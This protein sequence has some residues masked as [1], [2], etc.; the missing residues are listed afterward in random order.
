MN[1]D[2]KPYIFRGA[3]AGILLVLILLLAACG[4]NEPPVLVIPTPVNGT[5]AVPTIAPTAAVEL[6]TAAPSALVPTATPVAPQPSATLPPPPTVAPPLPTGTTG[7]QPTVAP[8]TVQPTVQPTAS[9]LAPNDP[10]AGSGYRVAF[11]AADD[12]LNVRRRPDPDSAVVAQLLPGTTGIRVIDEGR[13]VRGGSLWLPVE[14][15]SGDGWVNSRF[16]TE[17]V[18][19]DV[20]CAD[21]AVTEL[22][23]QLEKAIAE[24]DGRL[25]RSL[26]HPERGLRVRL[27][28]WNPEVEFAG[29]DVQTIF[30]ARIRYDWGTEDGSGNPIRGSFSDVAL[31]RLERDLLAATEWQCD[32]GVF[33]PT[34]GMTILPEGYEP[35]RFYSAHRAAPA[36]QELNWGTWLVGVERWEGRYYVSYLVHYRWE[37]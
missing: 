18:S 4:G 36:E 31:P 29:E 16:L 1:D 28:W 25:I 24:R 27:N 34:A 35:V 32:A 19:H 23:G 6:P 9:P 13:S 22:L 8:P 12:V 17:D 15:A 20:F 3:W 26:I 37:I 14:T 21:P 7:P 30:R 5:A 11:V 33:G 10:A 2:K